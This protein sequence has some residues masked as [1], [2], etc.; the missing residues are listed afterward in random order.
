MDDVERGVAVAQGELDRALER[1]VDELVGEGHR[2]WGVGDD[3]DAS[4]GVLLERGGD[5]GHVA[6][7][8]AHEK[9]L[10]VREGEQ[11]NLPRPAAV[12][13]GVEVELVHG[14]AAHVGLLALAQRLVGENL[15]RAA[16]DGRAGVDGGVARD[17]AD[18]VLAEKV[19]EVEELLAD[20]RLDGRRVVGAAV[21]AVGDEEHA[22]GDQALARAR[23]RPEDHVVV[24]RQ[25]EERLLLV[26]PELEA[27]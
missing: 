24:G 1:G 13:V 3:V 19:H 12:R 23:G 6:E 16:D 17:H 7:R 14:H 10:H 15:R 11:R 21:G 2:S 27:A 26:R 4:V 25:T 5:V 8:R 22:E 9:E 20:Q 18:V